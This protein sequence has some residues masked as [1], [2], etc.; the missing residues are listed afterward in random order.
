MSNDDVSAW[1][2]NVH[3]YAPPPTERLVDLAYCPTCERSR[4]ML[5]HLYEWHGGS[6]TC[7]GYGEAWNEDGRAERPFARDWRQARVRR[8]VAEVRSMGLLA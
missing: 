3:I 6:T 4:R 1:Y 2:G 5:V 7:L 8:A